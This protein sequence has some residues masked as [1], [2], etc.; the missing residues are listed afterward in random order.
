MVNTQETKKIKLC[1]KYLAKVP[2][3]LVPQ[4]HGGGWDAEGGCGGG[5]FVDLL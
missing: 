4:A 3:G 1:I 2:N 5:S